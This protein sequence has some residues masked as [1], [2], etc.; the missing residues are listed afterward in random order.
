MQ[1]ILLCIFALTVLYESVFPDDGAT[2]HS[3]ASQK[4]MSPFDITMWFICGNSVAAVCA[5][6]A[7]SSRIEECTLKS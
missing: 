6:M 5:D 2:S 1:P 7:S 3:A 4:S